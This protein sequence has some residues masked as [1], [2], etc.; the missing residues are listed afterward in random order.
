MKLICVDYKWCCCNKHCNYK[1]PVYDKHLPTSRLVVVDNSI[2]A[3]C[4]KDVLYM[5]PLIKYD[6]E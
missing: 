5:M 2:Y 4:M 6:E 1:Y 3:H